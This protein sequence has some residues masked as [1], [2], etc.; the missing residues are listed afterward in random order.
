M[1]SNNQIKM[2]HT[3]KNKLNLDEDIYRSMLSTYNV[4]SSKKLDF[5]DAKDLIT[6]LQKM[7]L[8]VGIWKKNKRRPSKYKELKGR[9]EM[10]TP[11]QLRM[12][13]GMWADVSYQETPEEREKALRKFLYRIVKVSDL[14][15]LKSTQV[16]KVIN[17]LKAMKW[18]KRS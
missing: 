8:E 17:A 11:A 12:I 13:E 18:Q 7:A 1:I 9:S 14:S 4:E 6:K 16:S 3:L 2:I 10:A 15:F 5:E